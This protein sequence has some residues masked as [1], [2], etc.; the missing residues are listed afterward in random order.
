M[1]LKRSFSNIFSCQ[2]FP[3]I[4]NV[5][6]FTGCFRILF[7]QN[8]W[9]LNQKFQPMYKFPLQNFLFFQNVWKCRFFRM[10]IF[11]NI[12]Q[13]SFFRKFSNTDFTEFSSFENNF[14]AHSQIIQYVR[15]L[16]LFFQFE[17]IWFPPFWLVQSGKDVGIC[18]NWS[19]LWTNNKLS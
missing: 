17:Q 4:W 10:F 14:K 15:L 8:E 13:S 16:L 5:Q 9:L 7:T 3:G 2:K 19:F 1:F 18:Q 11:Q 12:S 6:F